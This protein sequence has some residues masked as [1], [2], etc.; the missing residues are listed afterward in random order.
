MGWDNDGLEK[1]N[2]NFGEFIWWDGGKCLSLQAIL[3]Y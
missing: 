1:N 2:E 3:F